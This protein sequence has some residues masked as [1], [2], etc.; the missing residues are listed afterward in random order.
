[1]PSFA[2][3]SWETDLGHGN[4]DS[5]SDTYYVQLLTSSY[6]P[7][8]I[9]HSKRSDLSGESS[10]SG[11]AA[12]GQSC[13]LTLVPDSANKRV[14]YVFGAVSWPAATVTARYAAY[15]KRRGGLANADEL[16]AL[17]DFGADFSTAAATFYLSSTTVRKQL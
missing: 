11:Y 15:Y 7:N 6:V 10:G 3:L 8:Q 1:M 12:G 13:P 14:D 17:A 16:V 9:S 2:Y 5:D 4:L